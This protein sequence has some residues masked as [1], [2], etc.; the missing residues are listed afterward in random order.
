MSIT[1]RFRAAILRHTTMSG[2]IETPNTITGANAGGQVVRQFVRAGPPASL[3]SGV[4]RLCTHDISDAIASC[5]PHC[6]L[7][8]DV[9]LLPRTRDGVPAR[10]TRFRAGPLLVLG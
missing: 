1:G 5:P 8:D 3:S 10:A 6:E 9:G 2:I 4:R 7:G